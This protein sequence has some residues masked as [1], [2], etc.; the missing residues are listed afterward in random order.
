VR[1]FVNGEAVVSASLNWKSGC[2]ERGM[3]CMFEGEGRVRRLERSKS[4]QNV[5]LLALFSV[6]A[7]H[8][9]MLEYFYFQVIYTIK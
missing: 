4:W 2:V 1:N 3:K 8:Q 7:L 9:Y 5:V 6:K